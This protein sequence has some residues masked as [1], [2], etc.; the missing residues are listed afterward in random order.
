MSKKV[1]LGVGHG[2]TDPGAVGYVVEKDVNLTMALACKEYLE[3]NGVIVAINRIKDET[4]DLKI[5]IKECNEFNPDLALD[6][7]NNAG[8]GDGFEAYY[9]VGGGVGKTLAQ[10][11]EAEVKAIGQNSR[12][13]KVKK[14]SAGTD[15]F[16]FIRQT[17]CPAV[18][19]EG[20]FVDSAID[21]KIAD[22]IKEQK[23]FGYA[24]AR[25]ILKTLGIAEKKEP[26]KKPTATKSDE[27]YRVRKSWDNPKSQIGAFKNLT[28]AKS[29]VNRN[30]GYSV[31]NSKGKKV[32][33]IADKKALD[34]LAKDVINGKYG[35]G[36]ARKKAITTAYKT[37]K[38]AY[39]YD[40]I[41]KRVN[42]LV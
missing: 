26:T 17:N 8:K 22:T 18:L 12:G 23:E 42:E 20:V 28:N 25:G 31:Y 32:Y 5:R 9:T 30:P 40:E 13:I 19:L 29:Q 36:T 39:S 1:F 7:H 41:Q 14:N 10:N 6:I 4:E 33:P 16:G 15:H 11:I 34:A 35:N 38:I 2:G 3:A 37:G 27:V 24:Y 21:V